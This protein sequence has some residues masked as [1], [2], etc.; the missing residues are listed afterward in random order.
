[1]RPR[2]Y[3]NNAERQKAYRERVKKLKALRKSRT[4]VMES[5][6]GD[7]TE[8]RELDLSRLLKL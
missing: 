5:L 6:A 3:K 2:L 7:L 4:N 1:M 8:A